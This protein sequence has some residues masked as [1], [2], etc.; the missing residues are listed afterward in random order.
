V[1]TDQLD[2]A[3]VLVGDE[4]SILKERLAETLNARGIEPSSSFDYNEYDAAEADVQSV[5]V[6]ALTPPFLSDVRATVLRRA[7]RLSDSEAEVL[8]ETVSKLPDGALFIL[9]FE[10]GE[11]ATS[12][13]KDLIAAVKK[14]GRF[15]D[16]SAPKSAQIAKALQDKVSREG[17]SADPGAMQKLVQ[18]VEGEY[19]DAVMEL[20]KLFALCS[21]TKQISAAQVEASVK[22]SRRWRVFELLDAVSVGDLGRALSNWKL[23]ERSSGKFMDSVTRELFPHIS[24][25]LRLLW[26]AKALQEAGISITHTDAAKFCP[27][28]YSLIS[29]YERSDWAA[30]KIMRMAQSLSLDRIGRMMR[31][32]VEADLRLK[33]QMS[34]ANETESI[35]RMLAE[36]CAAASNR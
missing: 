12:A 22:E 32:L 21:E 34:A 6:S 9:V 33:G 15:V 3:Y 5:M 30:N 25:Q 2:K 26:Q 24:R 13:R 27:E 4:P 35:E 23:L 18:L 8:I 1:S 28:K 10:S 7:D 17:Y 29:Q 19:G 11:K 31:C 16:C 20:D 14:C 36:M